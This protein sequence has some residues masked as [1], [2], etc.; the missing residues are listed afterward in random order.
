MAT[1]KKYV[2]SKLSDENTGPIYRQ[3][4]IDVEPV[5]GYLK[6]N[7][8][9]TRFSIRGT[10]KVKNE[11][12]FALMAVNLGKYTAKDLHEKRNNPEKRD[13][14]SSHSIYPFLLMQTGFCASL[15]FN[16]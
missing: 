12:G 9:F 10:S 16:F 15:F 13:N 5:F 6:A 8:R 1:T 4:K 11:M 14:L 7:L 3:C 2:K